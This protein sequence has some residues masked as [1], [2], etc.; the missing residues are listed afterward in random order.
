MSCKYVKRHIGSIKCFEY[1]VIAKNVNLHNYKYPS[2]H[3]VAL[4][5]MRV[6][7]RLEAIPTTI[8][9]GAVYTLDR[10]PIRHRPFF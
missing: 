8:W 7:E 3:S 2:V 9:R 4:I 10:M 5:L 6:T 1:P